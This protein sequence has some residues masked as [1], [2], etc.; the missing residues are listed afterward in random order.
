MYREVLQNRNYRK[1]LAANAVNR[2]GD[3]VDSIA[4][5]WL[6]YTATESA[7]ISALVFAANILPTALFQPL[8]A[9]VVDKWKKKSV[10]MWADWLRGLL[11]AGFIGLLLQNRLTPW[12][13]VAFTFFIN[14]V[15]AF[16]IPAGVAYLPKFLEGDQLDRGI[17][18]NQ[19]TDQVFTLAG[20]AAGGVLAAFSPALAMGIDL[21]SFLLSGLFIAGMK[22]DEVVDEAVR[23]SGYWTNLKGGFQYLRKNRAF[24]IFVTVALLSNMLACV[25]SALAAA[26]VSG[27]LHE[28][29]TYL[30]A[31][32][33]ILTVCGLV[34]VWLYPKLSGHFRPS[35]LLTWFMFGVSGLL[36]L[37]LAF[38]PGLTGTGRTAAW[39]LLFVVMGLS[40]GLTGAF[41]NIMFVKVVEQAYLA[42][43]AGVFNSAVTLSMPV[44]SFLLA[45]VVP[46][47]GIPVLLGA[48]GVLS[49]AVLAVFRL[50]GNCKILDAMV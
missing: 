44:M 38:L 14:T 39:A 27:V 42:R 30:S 25:F 15:E 7:S 5:T 49:L 43:A 33:M 17:N 9:P 34:M 16:R 21:A 36:Y 50:R 1:L 6:A 31:A 37:G 28:P 29:P 32:E 13:F 45:A 46:I 4:F 12:M 11:L 8:V 47:T 2:L 26:Y 48:A 40:S 22:V 23:E 18:L 20:T 19:I 41:L 3:G 10:M 24:G 35:I